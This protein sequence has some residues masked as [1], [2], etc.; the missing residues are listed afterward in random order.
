M[1]N[2]DLKCTDGRRRRA[3]LCCRLP[4]RMMR[5]SSTWSDFQRIRSLTTF[6]ARFSRTQ[7]LTSSAQDSQATSANSANTSH[8]WSSS[9]KS[10]T[11]STFRKSIRKSTPTSKKTAALVSQPSANEWP[12]RRYAKR[13]RFRTGRSDHS[14]IVRSTMRVWMLIF[15]LLFLRRFFLGRTLAKIKIAR[16]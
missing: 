14:G 9:N 11:S 15:F 1:L 6:F 13:S 7:K 2:G 10:Q 5:S 12:R 16:T 3:Q 8:I 4:G